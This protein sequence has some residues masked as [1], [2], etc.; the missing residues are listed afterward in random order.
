[1][2]TDPARKV[3]L[4]THRTSPIH[5]VGVI[6]KTQPTLHITEVT[7]GTKEGMDQLLLSDHGVERL[8]KINLPEQQ[9]IISRCLNNFSKHVREKSILIA[10]DPIQINN[11]EFYLLNEFYHHIAELSM[12]APKE[13]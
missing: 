3:N 12:S 8:L 6:F 9:A 5:R 10:D 1:R 4:L 13:I 2:Y 7:G 11:A